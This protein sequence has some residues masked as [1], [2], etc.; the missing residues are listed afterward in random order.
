MIL[1]INGAELVL[2]SGLYYAAFFDQELPQKTSVPMG[3]SQVMGKLSENVNH[4]P[5]KTSIEYRERFH[6]GY[7]II[8]P[9]RIEDSA[10][11]TAAA[12]T[13]P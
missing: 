4:M 10:A 13:L 9:S 3:G 1:L 5:H 7:R 6:K 11:A 2:M 8:L 12:H